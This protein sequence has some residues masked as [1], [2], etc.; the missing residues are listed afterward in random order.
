M[1][2]I[3][4]THDLAVAICAMNSERTIRH[5]L[6]SMAGLARRVVVVDS[7]ST[8]GTIDICKTHGA[9]VIHRPWP[10][11]I[12]Q[13]QFAV[14]QVK[15]CTW[16]LVL[17]SDE[18]P[19]PALRQSIERVL[20]ENDPAFDG[21]FVNRKVWFMNGWLHHVYQPEWRLRLFRTARSKVTGV[22][23]HYQIEVQGRAGKLKGDLRH[24]AWAD[25]KDMAMRHLRYAEL[26]GRE[27]PENG[28]LVKVLVNPP[29]AIF[30][31]LVLKRGF[32]DGWR[33]VVAAGMVANSIMLKHAFMATAKHSQREGR[34]G[35]RGR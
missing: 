7:G 17:D 26:A 6:Q 9:E 4:T 5:T 10:G 16:C 19:E 1:T 20:Q 14:D 24:D 34:G 22:N 3:T 12:E 18:S 23:P 29:A 30:K 2:S 13:V 11:F 31:Q 32:L 8:D 27:T 33:G 35:E 25:M 15:D 21:W 28:S